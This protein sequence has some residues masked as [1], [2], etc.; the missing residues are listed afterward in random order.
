MSNAPACSAETRRPVG[1]FWSSIRALLVLAF[2]ED[3]RDVTGID[4][5]SHEHV[6][7]RRD[8]W[9]DLADANLAGR[10]DGTSLLEATEIKATL[11]AWRGRR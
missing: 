1:S 3:S 10:R 6:A 4:V 8:R 7:T 9:T 2:K 5:G 11:Q